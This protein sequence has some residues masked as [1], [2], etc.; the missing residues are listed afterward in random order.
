ME[1]V[2]PTR[3]AQGKNKSP[4]YVNSETIQT[5]STGRA[6]ELKN[7]VFVRRTSS[8]LGNSAQNGSTGYR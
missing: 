7:N 8:Y 4:D 5:F 1:E 2:N 3:Q 6:A